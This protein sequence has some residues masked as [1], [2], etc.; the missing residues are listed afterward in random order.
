MNKGQRLKPRVA[1]VGNFSKEEELKFNNIFPTIWYAGNYDH[2]ASQIHQN[3]I[4]LLIVGS[5]INSITILEHFT[6]FSLFFRY[7]I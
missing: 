2:L 4:D 3:E 1:I 5:D 6:S 7:S